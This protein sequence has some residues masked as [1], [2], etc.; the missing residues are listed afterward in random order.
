M[1]NGDLPMTT[2]SAK[3]LLS[4]VVRGVGGGWY[5]ECE[6]IGIRM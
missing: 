1:D 5:Y 3:H 4:L 6:L 2:P